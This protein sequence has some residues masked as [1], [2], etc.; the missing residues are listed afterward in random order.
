MCHLDLH[1]H[2]IVLDHEGQVWLLDWDHAG[3]YPVY[4]EN[5]FLR[6]TIDHGR[7][8]F[9]KGLESMLTLDPELRHE[10]LRLEG[11]RFAVTT[12]ALVGRR[13]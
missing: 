5:L 4:F 12:A 6:V 1:T 3:A 10:L 8:D 7:H 13:T 11:M 2:N 9:I